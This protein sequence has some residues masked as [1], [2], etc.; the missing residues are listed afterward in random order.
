MQGGRMP[1]VMVVSERRRW[2]I[3]RG[4]HDSMMGE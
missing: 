2:G 4:I 1:G 3:R